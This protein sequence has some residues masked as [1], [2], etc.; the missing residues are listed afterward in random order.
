MDHRQHPNQRQHQPNQLSTNPAGGFI[1]RG[2]FVVARQPDQLRGSSGNPV[3]TERLDQLQVANDN[4][5]LDTSDPYFQGAVNGA[6]VA[7]FDDF[8]GR[9]RLFRSGIIRVQGMETHFVQGYNSTVDMANQ[10]MSTFQNTDDEVGTCLS[11][12]GQVTP[13]LLR[14]QQENRQQNT[15][16]QSS[17]L[18]QQ[19]NHRQF[20]AHSNSHTLNA[21][22][23][24]DI[25]RQYGEF[26]QQHSHVASSP[27]TAATLSTASRVP[28]L[29][30]Q[31]LNMV[32]PQDVGT[33]SST[34][35]R[36][37]KPVVDILSPST[38]GRLTWKQVK[39]QVVQDLKDGVV[40][41]NAKCEQFYQLEGRDYKLAHKPSF[42]KGLNRLRKHELE[43]WAEI[44]QAA[45]S[46]N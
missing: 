46:E 27:A 3:N 33:P 44:V 4:A 5:Y 16:F 12:I 2:R 20:F 1:P 37:H 34:P 39:P 14:V 45:N 22:R 8:Q 43:L 35:R 10:G 30:S 9:S 11:L 32:N 40:D 38:P 18:D 19:E 29:T 13:I 25:D 42:S 41:L 15:Y 24:A 6:P 31:Q 26:L 21:S 7:N 36:H 28:L 23:R 17:M